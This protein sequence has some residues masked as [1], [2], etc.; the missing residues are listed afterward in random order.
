MSNNSN[1]RALSRRRLLRLAGAAGAAGILTHGRRAQAQAAD[2]INFTTWSA[3]VDQVKSHIT[4]FEK[5]TGLKVNYQN[6]PFAQ[7]RE[8]LVTRFVGN[9]PMDVMWVSDAWLPEWAEARWLA[10]IGDMP[11][12]TRYNGD[13]DA[14]CN[15]SM[16]Y[17][18]QQYGLT[19][20]SDH[21]SFM[22]NTELLQKAGIAAPP[23]SWD[24]VTQQALKIKQ[25]GLADFPVLLPLAVESWQIEFIT[26]M[27]YSFGGGFVDDKNMAVMADPRRGALA[28]LKWVHD[29]I[30]VHKIVS[31]GAVETGE[32]AA[33]K[34]MGGGTH[35]FSLTP[36]YRIRTLNDP[37][38]AQAAG[39]IRIALMPQGP[40]GSN[41]TVGWIRFYGMTPA[42][43]R[44]RR[45]AENAAKLI[46]WFGGKD[47]L[48]Y[49]FQKLLLV[50]LG[51]PFCVKPLN[52]DPQVK[53]HYDKWAGGSD[54]VV[55][56]NALARKKDTIAPWFGEWNEVHGKAWQAALIGRSTP[57]AALKSA[58]DKWNE[59][60]RQAG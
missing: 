38:Q 14:F 36:R 55:R 9:A 57:E 35:A 15:E 41:A 40:N 53:A 26:A 11:Q 6:F 20:Y 30:H 44:D 50:D 58:A 8:T 7:Y 10:P 45:R 56:Q 1:L 37:T 12:L 25:A 54:I 42:T 46:E 43:K 4:A 5:K 31:P 22:Y 16:V 13:V 48:G 52:D 2:T 23:K 17:K 27:V 33:L 47:D 51:V 32:L 21:M 28:A 19:Y 59:L 3:A 60:R 24:E 39:K 29:A 34:A 18:G 49:T